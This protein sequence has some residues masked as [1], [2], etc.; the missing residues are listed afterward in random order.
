MLQNI[1]P[2]RFTL[3]LLFTI[4]FKSYAQNGIKVGDT[5]S[6]FHAIDQYQDTLDL[7]SML[8]DKKVVIIFYRG[9][10]CPFCMRHLSTLEDSLA[11][12]QAKDC[13]VIVVT[14]EK[15]AD[16]SQA[17]EKTNAHYSIVYDKSYT[18][19]KLFQVNFSQNHSNRNPH[20]N[21]I[22][23]PQLPVPA[24]YIVNQDKTIKWR[25]FDKNYTQRASIKS[26]LEHL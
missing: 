22:I 7:H 10:W 17:I 5:V 19:M 2:I 14:P 6:N 3:L 24:T 12:L 16:I 21:K 4:S 13:K 18:I 11:L 20:P 9:H 26:I 8:S 25:H 15:P 23:G 1:N